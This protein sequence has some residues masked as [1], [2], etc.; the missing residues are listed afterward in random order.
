MDTKLVKIKL[1]D[2]DGYFSD[3]YFIITEQL[4][5]ECRTYNPYINHEILMDFK[6]TQRQRYKSFTDYYVVQ[7][8]KVPENA[9]CQDE[10]FLKCLLV[11]NGRYMLASFPKPKKMYDDDNDDSLEYFTQTNSFY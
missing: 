9:T 1:F 10:Q 6:L 4:L 5:K 8:E 11:K 7:N 2:L 3:K